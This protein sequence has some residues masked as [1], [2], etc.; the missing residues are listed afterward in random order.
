MEKYRPPKRIYAK[1]IIIKNSLLWNRPSVPNQGCDTV[2][3][4]KCFRTLE[5]EAVAGEYAAMVE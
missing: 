5:G 2:L 1:L 4:G 3:H